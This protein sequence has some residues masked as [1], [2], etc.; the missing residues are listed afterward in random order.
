MKILIADDFQKK[1]IEV[2]QAQGHEVSFNP[3]LTA[4]TLPS[5]IKD[6]DCLIVRGTKVTEQTI[7]SSEKL[8]LIIRAGSGI[9]T[10][11]LDAA[12]KKAVF[13]TNT[14]A[15]NS[16]AIAELAFG[17]MISLDRKIPENVIDLRNSKWNMK[18]YSEAQGLYEKTVGIVGM[19][20][21][22]IEFADRAK[23]FGM[24]VIAFDPIALM[25]RPVAI[26]TR[27]ERKIFTFCNTLEEIAELSDVIT[28]HLPS[29]PHTKNMVNRDFLK[30]VKKNA[31]IINTSRGDI[32]DDDALIEAI[33][34]KNLRVGLDTFNGEPA[35]GDGKFESALSKHHNVY[36]TH[37]IGASTEQAQNAIA[38][39]VIEIITQYELGIVKYPVNIEMKPITRHILIA[40]IYDK[41]G[42]FASILNLLKEQ[43]ISVQQMDSKVFNGEITQQIVLYLS[44]RPDN[45]C[46]DALSKL[47]DV[48]QISVKSIIS[49]K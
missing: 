18:K 27:L 13:V 49:E 40:R 21:I 31:I 16:I 3:D 46:I 4:E 2:L 36:G 15:R 6:N 14:P 7:E 17:L 47:S 22:G 24:N 26:S 33:N 30:H 12:A 37:H 35:K 41:V 1:Y 25:N 19:G 28:F 38:A 32:V 45:A 44:K 42:V 48:I 34:S 11:D 8:S 9:S 5:A 10:I 23:A 29:N 43:S 39:E 20:E